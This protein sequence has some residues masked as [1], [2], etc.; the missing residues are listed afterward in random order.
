MAFSRGIHAVNF[1]HVY[2]VVIV[3]QKGVFFSDLDSTD[4]RKYF[5]TSC[6]Q[7]EQWT[8]EISEFLL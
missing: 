3:L 7:V 8:T 2:Y 5:K 1:Q 4:T 6:E